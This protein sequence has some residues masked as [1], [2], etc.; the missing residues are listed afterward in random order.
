M[1]FLHKILFLLCLLVPSFAHAQ[2]YVTGDDPGK[3][4][5]NY[6]DTDNFR[7]IYP[8]GSDS[9]ARQYAYKLEKYKIPVSR[10]TGYIAGEGDGKLMPAVLH[11]YNGANG[12]VAWAPKRMD[13]F[14]LP[15]AY[16]PEPMPWSTMLAVH[17]GR[18]VTQM[19]FGMTGNQKPFGYVFGQMWNILV[20]L[21]YPGLYGIEGD[22][23]IAETALTQSGRGRTAD[24][25]NYYRIA[26]DQED[27]RTW[28]RWQFGSQRHYTPD[29]Y[30]LGY[31][32]LGAAR[33]LYDYPMLMKDGYNMASRKIFNLSPFVTLIQERSGKKFEKEFFPEVRDT[34]QAIWSRDAQARA[35]FIPMEKVTEE[36]RLYT[37]YTNTVVDKS[38]I[39]TIKKGYLDSPELIKID[40]FGQESLISHLPHE[41][42]NL[43]INSGMLYWSE[44]KP[45]ERW[46]MKSDSRIRY[47]DVLG[48]KHTLSRKD[49]F[50]YNPILG[51]DKI[52]TTQYFTDGGS[53]LNIDGETY[54]APD[55]LQIV[56]SACINDI[57]YATAI[58]DNGFGIYSFD[59]GVWSVVLEPQ[60]VKITDFK[61]V[62]SELAFTCDRTSVNEIYHLDPVSGD[63]RQ[64][65][66][67]KYG[68]SDFAYSDDGRY[69]YFSSPTLKGLQMFRTPVDSLINRKVDFTEKYSYVIADCLSE[70][71]RQLA[72]DAGYSE[73]VN[74]DL[75]IEDLYISEPK[76]YRKAA[77]LFYIHSWAPVYVSVD[78]IMNMSFDRIFQAA[79]LG[80]SAIM[81]N[82][83]ST[84]VGEFGYSAHKDPYDR[85]KW[86]H[87]GH[88]KFTYSG[89]YPVIEAKI[90][91]NDRAARQFNTTY[92]KQGKEASVSMTSR[93][94][95]VPYF[96]GRFSTY[97]PFNFSSGGWYRG[98]IPKLSYTV[99]ND[100]F[101][102]SGA[103]LENTGAIEGFQ[104]PGNNPPFIGATKGK[105]AFR[106]Y[107][108]GSLRFYTTLST[109]NSAVYPRWGFGIE[110]G[111]NNS[112]N[113]GKILSPMG[114]GY[115]YGYVPGFTREQGM[116][117]SVMH[118]QKLDKDAIF[119]QP[120]VSVLPRG[121]TS[122]A[123]LSSYMA[124]YN[125]AI[126][127]FSAD[128]AI[129]IYIGDISIGGGL[130]YI[131]R[132][133]LTPHV[134]YTRAG[135]TNL[136]SVGSALTFDLN[137]LIWIGWPVSIGATYSY[138][139]LADYNAVKASTGLDMDLHHVGFVF[140]VSF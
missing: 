20:S 58:S 5:W 18:H 87:S 137:G 31:M 135:K 128:Y 75:N 116:K 114:Y 127:K 73:A 60:P 102:T 48:G 129:P 23:V 125:P 106:H 124:I 93:E 42:S 55:S 39:Y 119:G 113:T 7:V 84:G 95:D 122:T 35:P 37:D 121:L 15:T 96:E 41:V 9:L 33:Y 104:Y 74:E 101:N 72:A 50:L 98:L 126:T 99:T 131:K 107:L 3:L 139:G 89:L 28:D 16:N 109:P 29:H 53:A 105:N 103:V 117:L 140:N 8:M 22:A 38:G 108:T 138:N 10:S 83:H 62:G 71:E 57:I 4:K 61:S 13:L 34:M 77:N 100:M 123:S 66:S 88:F 91:F 43:R 136:M 40:M 19:Q 1:K 65:T 81:Q 118:Q 56:E 82:R 24:F 12:S 25:L 132:L 49:K 90:D 115:I 80:A 44:E 2:F 78:N 85:S 51:G 79:S 112:F 26:F 45:D 47:I 76:R 67:T 133:C 111:A 59:N 32:T 63:L 92:F 120:M 46:S 134:D 36:P 17:E 94:L 69:L 110:M 97:I 14:T 21:V 52:I 70:Q 86:R 11:T 68:A 30:A 27:Y 130:V 64:K 54:M 6:I